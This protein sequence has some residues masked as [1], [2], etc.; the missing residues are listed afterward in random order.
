M[1]SRYATNILLGAIA[2]LLLVCS[3]AFAAV[4]FQWIMLGAGI[5][6]TVVAASAAAIRSRGYI[7][8]GLDLVAA[9]VGVWTIIASLVFS[10][11]VMTWLGFASGGALAIL[12]VAGLTAHELS[13]ERVVHSLEVKSETP[14]RAPAVPEGPRQ[15]ARTA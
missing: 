10:G 2:G 6:A 5:A 9:A 4:T 14:P 8:R 1:N 13:T 15:H 7:Q 11:A 12:A 3:F